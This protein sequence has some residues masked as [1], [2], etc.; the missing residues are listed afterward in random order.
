MT[1]LARWCFRRGWVVIVAWVLALAGLGGVGSALGTTYSDGFQ[2]PDTESARALELMKEAFPQQAGESDTVVWHV[3]DGSVRDASVKERMAAALADIAKLPDVGA[4]A[5]PYDKGGKGRISRDGRTAYATVTLAKQGK[6]LPEGLV[7]Q[8]MD[9]ARAPAGKG[10]QVELGGKAVAD[11]ER[12]PQNIAEVVGIIAAAVVLFLAF[13]SLFGMLLPIVTALFAIGTASFL[14]ILLSHGVEIPQIAPILS[15]LVG[16]GVGIDYALF[17]ITRYRKA[18]LRGRPL[19]EAAVQ[20][21]DT[22]GRAVLFAGGTVCIALLGMFAMGMTFLNGVAIAASLSVVFTVAAAV[23]LLPA[24]LGVLGMRILS[25]RQRRRLAANGSEPEAVNGAAARWSTF[26]ERHP[27]MLTVVAVAVMA[28]LSI[29]TL[30]LRLGSSDQGNNP[31]S[32]TSRKAYDLLADGFGPGFNGPLQ[33]VTEVPGTGDRA[34]VA[35]LAK[36]LAAVK[37]VAQVAQLPLPP[38]AGIAVLS[39]VPTTSPQSEETSELIDHLRE[40]VVPAAE[41]GTTMKAHVGGAT[42]T[43]KDFAQVLT[44][45]LPMFIAIIVALGFVLLLIAFRSLLVPLTAAAMNLIA[46]VASF[47]LVIVVF[48]WGWGV[49]LLGAG[50]EG[51]IEPF[52]PVIMLS[53]LFGLSMDYQVFL[54]SRM[55]EEWVHTG[56]NAR[57]VRVGLTETSRVI[58]SA[59]VIMICVFGAFI[60][61]GQRIIALFGI[62]LAGAVALDAFILRTILVPALMYQFGAAN[63][64]LPRAIDKRLPHL[65]VDPPDRPYP[66]VSPELEGEREL[67]AER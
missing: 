41:R 61:S 55:H 17:I 4:V 30:S 36:D 27:R 6:D 62:G 47:G 5:S 63:W 16:L 54:V 12:P 65:A 37:G 23:T 18:I 56:D 64:W 15:T 35:T 58:N 50:K 66:G 39:V 3:T 26:V 20:A 51:P 25:R 21:V 34:A 24:M 38:D 42:A 60:L 46:A 19:E 13:G 45:K 8:M 40:D 22:S 53:L 14:V 32:T 49:E 7:E 29:P 52:L 57:A 43:Y 59:A 2:L 28:A 1:A 33:I 11:A 10:L 48:Q 9:T 67:A 44:G 31:S